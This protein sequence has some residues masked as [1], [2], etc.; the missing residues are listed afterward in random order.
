MG[1]RAK[2]ESG[3]VERIYGA[4][5][6]RP[7]KKMDLLAIARAVGPSL[8]YE[9]VASNTA[10]A[11]NRFAP[12]L[13]R[14]GHGA[15]MYTP[16]GHADDTRYPEP[17]LRFGAVKDTRTPLLRAADEKR[18]QTDGALVLAASPPPSEAKTKANGGPE[19]VADHLK[20]VTY[21]VLGNM[22][23]GGVLLLDSDMVP[24]KLVPMRLVPA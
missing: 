10:H 8:S 18:A 20:R 15:Y 12:Y 21:T 16:G 23:D 13:R 17:P 14:V 7:Y 6:E 19:P 3:A 24:W 5:R 11:R 22:D 9:A 1:T 2:P 4:L